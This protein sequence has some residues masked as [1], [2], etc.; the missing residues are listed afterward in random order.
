PKL[1]ALETD[2]SPFVGKG[3]PR[4]TGEV[5]WLRPE[6]VAEI[7]YE[8]FTAD[9]LLRQAAFK[10]LREDKPAEEVEA[11][12]PA[13]AVTTELRDPAPTTIRT[14]TVTPQSSAV[15][16]GVTVSHAS[17]TLWPDAGDGRP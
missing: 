6:L 3:S 7:E 15:V 17:K 2:K 5:H 10:A 14:K 12:I 1:K 13:P 9:G 11:E 4:N 8:G 16:M